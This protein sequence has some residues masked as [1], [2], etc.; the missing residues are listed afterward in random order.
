[1][2]EFKE[3]KRG[4]KGLK[5]INIDPKNGSVVGFKIV[6]PEEELMIL[7]NEGHVIRLYIDDISVQKRY[8]RG[9]LL[10]KTS[11]DDEVA[12]L[13]RFKIDNED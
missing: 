10:M 11:P 6:T 13:T 2:N 5:T 4:G 8:S 1:M 7:T 12:A 3:Q 9:V